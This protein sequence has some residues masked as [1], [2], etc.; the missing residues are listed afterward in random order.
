MELRFDATLCSNLGNENY[1]A[2]HIKFSRGPHLA[3]GQ[4]FPHPCVKLSLFQDNERSYSLPYRVNC[5]T[6][7]IFRGL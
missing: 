7:A 3:R 1:N 5:G 4:Q 2:G 6:Q